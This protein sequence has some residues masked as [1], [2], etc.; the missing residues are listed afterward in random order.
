MENERIRASCPRC[1]ADKTKIRYQNS[2]PIVRIY[3]SECGLVFSLQEAKDHGFSDPI[4]YWNESVGI[5]Y[6]MDDPPGDRYIK[7]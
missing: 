5:Y 6:P 1:F 7:P 3:C 4:D 2:G